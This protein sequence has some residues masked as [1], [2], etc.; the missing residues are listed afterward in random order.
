MYVLPGEAIRAKERIRYL[1][2]TE[3]NN[4]KLSDI[5]L[6]FIISIYPSQNYNTIKTKL[7]F[8]FGTNVEESEKSNSEYSSEKIKVFLKKFSIED[9]NIQ[10]QFYN[11]IKIILQFLDFSNNQIETILSEFK[12][13]DILKLKKD[14]NKEWLNNKLDQLIGLKDLKKD[15]NNLL[16]FINNNIKRRQMNLPSSDISM[17]MVFLGSPGTGKTTIARMI[18]ELY[19]KLEI[20][21]NEEVIEVSR[22][23]LVAEYL[24]QTAVKTKKV[25]NSAKGGV[26]FIDEAYSL[27]QEND[28]YGIEAI[29]TILKFME[30]NRDDTIIILAG[31]EEPMKELLK[32]NPGLESRFNKFFYFPNYSTEE[33]IEILKKICKSKKYEINEQDLILLTNKIESIDKDTDTFGNARYIR[34]LFEKAI[35][36]QAIRLENSQTEVSDYDFLQ[37]KYSD[38]FGNNEC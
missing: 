8:L 7:N 35:V 5:L 36:N 32:S 27:T 14:Q 28:S 38:F 24:G 23:D 25:L 11:D 6:D 13:N 16:D 33:L 20:I 2:K 17:H 29:N 21:E 12:D 34:N 26:L 10:E 18:G 15:V 1:Y 30:D 19:H 31:Y 3:E 9:K 4:D 22:E 37:L